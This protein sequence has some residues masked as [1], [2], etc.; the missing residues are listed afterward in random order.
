MS[1]LL[2]AAVACIA[3][4]ANASPAVLR[5]DT[6]MVS[7]SGHMSVLREYGE[8][9]TLEQVREADLGGRFEALP[10]Y[11]G[12][13]Y[14][15]RPHWVKIELDRTPESS[16]E[17]LLEVE[18]PYLDNIQLYRPNAEGGYTRVQGGDTFPFSSRAIIHRNTVFPLPLPDGSTTLYLRVATTST[19]IVAP[20]FWQPQAFAQSAQREY[21]MWGCYL[22]V[23]LSVLLFGVLNGFITGRRDYYAYGAYVLAQGLEASA[24]S[25]LLGQFVFPDV[26]EWANAAVGVTIAWS[27]IASSLLFS[28]L[29]RMRE[30]YPRLQRLY[31]AIIGVAGVTFVAAMTPYYGYLA[32]PL[33]MMTL[34]AT[35]WTLK[36][37][38]DF[39]RTHGATEQRWLGGAFTVF[40]VMVVGNLTNVLGLIPTSLIT[41][42]AHRFLALIFVLIMHVGVLMMVR[43]S[44]KRRHTALESV[45]DAERSVILERRA[46]EERDQFLSMFNH[47]VRTPLS[48]IRASTQSLEL[49]DT[50]PEP[51]RQS[52]YRNI[53]DAVDR[54]QKLVELCLTTD[55][56]DT[57]NWVSSPIPTD[58]CDLTRT[59]LSLLGT[60]VYER[61][62]F[63]AVERSPIMGD[64]ELIRIVFLNLLDNAFK[65]S[66]ADS[67]ITITIGASSE[68]LIEWVIENEGSAWAPGDEE[69]LFDKYFRVAEH[70][71]Q[72]GL[73]LGLFLVRRIMEMHD[74]GIAAELHENGPRFHCRFPLRITETQ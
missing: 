74:G 61:I 36:P 48:I 25:G 33:M 8:P 21:L 18:P 5:L 72:P 56:F 65:Y 3:L 70:A 60:E 64:P 39:L 11:L 31:Q 46:R 55:R 32:F 9:M 35:V 45:R 40:A 28:W 34:V 68:G 26:P 41:I 23:L 27:V 13:G 71:G 38:W 52:R 66:R 20:R 29:F 50:S 4:G 69:R 44:E 7:A 2:L 19:M 16:P 63:H 62:Q 54:T 47:E 43:E 42:Y 6:D 67:P 24:T 58:L 30:N 59:T 15:S 53:I 37:A 22:G 17:W 1:W 10:G 12:A 73:G 51:S 14:V 49:L 57:G